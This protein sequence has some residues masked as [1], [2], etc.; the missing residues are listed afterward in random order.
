MLSVAS[1]VA[2]LVGLGR[3]LC[4]ALARAAVAVDAGVESL[5]ALVVGVDG[6]VDNEVLGADRDHV[7]LL[8]TVYP[9]CGT[10][11]DGLAH[12]QVTAHG[13]KTDGVH[14]QHQGRV[15]GE[16]EHH[17]AAVHL[18]ARHAG[19]GIISLNAIEERELVALFPV[20]IAA[21]E[22]RAEGSHGGAVVDDE[23]AEVDVG[24]HNV[25][26]APG[27]EDGRQLAS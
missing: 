1:G 5:L 23:A 25:A 12:A 15:V 8:T 13:A 22:G 10:F 7:V 6:R 19:D 11:G 17:L 21:D 14:H 24:D 4:R 9:G 20:L 26:S 18:G 27:V 16:V 2:R 3:A